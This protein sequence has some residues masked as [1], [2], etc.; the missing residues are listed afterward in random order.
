MPQNVTFHSALFQTAQILL[1]IVY[2]INQIHITELRD[3]LLPP[4]KML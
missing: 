1:H 2:L 4:Q 3:I